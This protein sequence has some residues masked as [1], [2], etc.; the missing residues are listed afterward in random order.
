MAVVG[1]FSLL[2]KQG[3]A[4]DAVAH[5]LL[6]GICLAFL[7]SGRKA[8][9]P[10]LVGGTVSSGLALALIHHLSKQTKL[11][12]EGTVALVMATFLGIGMLLLTQ[13]QQSGQAAQAGLQQVLIGNAASL[14]VQEAYL[15]IGFALL[16]LWLLL[17]FFRPWRLLSF[18]PAFAH[19]L[20]WPVVALHRLF[21]LITLWSILLGSQS[22]GIILMSAMLIL[23]PAAAAF[24]SDCLKWR[25]LIAGLLASLGSL[26]AVW[27]S[28]TMSHL[29]IGPITALVFALLLFF[30][31]LFAPKKGWLA[32]QRNAHAYNQQVIQENLLK[33]AFN[34]DQQKA[35]SLGFHSASELMEGFW[36]QATLMVQLER[37]CAQGLMIKNALNQ[38]S[39]TP[40][41]NAI[42]ASLLKRHLLWERYLAL[43][44]NTKADHLQQD[45]E[46]VEHLITAELEDGLPK[47]LEKEGK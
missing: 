47:A 9:L 40:R 35:T 16:L 13:I 37:L 5:A 31:F 39:L 15:L 3:L 7:W 44:L 28:Y 1:T 6:P 19:S 38:W 46:G 43:Q 42:G 33:K 34:L 20:G 2:Q 26:T 10:L 17:L 32:N 4:G 27:F 11:N 29:P 36:S 30:S 41:G 45:A 12:K 25:L 14:L 23:P 22:M 21:S 18:D 8:P 24:W